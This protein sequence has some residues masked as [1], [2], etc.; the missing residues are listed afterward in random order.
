L[1]W[2]IVAICIDRP[3]SEGA[4]PSVSHMI[5]KSSRVADSR[6]AATPGPAASRSPLPKILMVED[7]ATYAGLV[8]AR[9]AQSDFDCD[10]VASVAEAEQAISKTAYAA[11]LLDLGL[12][13]TEN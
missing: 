9:L 1:F 7:N 4:L 12:V 8:M 11:I 6:R 13:P 3:I 2:V 10:L 5:I